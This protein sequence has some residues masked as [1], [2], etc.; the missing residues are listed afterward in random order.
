[1]VDGSVRR[2]IRPFKEP[3]S[4][5]SSQCLP[6]QI[7]DRR[8]VIIRAWRI[9]EN[10]SKSKFQMFYLLWEKQLQGIRYYGHS[11]WNCVVISMVT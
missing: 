3:A 5:P 8:T 10:L 11:L 2:N 6:S 4:N 1:L 9:L 7:A